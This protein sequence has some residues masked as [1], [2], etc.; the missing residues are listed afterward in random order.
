MAK[1]I[2]PVVGFHFNVSFIGLPKTKQLIVGFQSVDGLNVKSENKF[3]K[4]GGENRFIHQLPSQNIYKPLILKKG[5]I[6]EEDS[7]LLNWCQD[8]FQNNIKQPISGIDI[9]VL[10]EQHKVLLRWHLFHVWPLRWE[11]G[12]LNAE[13]GEIL[14]E[15]LV[16]K[17]NYFQLV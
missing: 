17:Y 14:I 12:K 3:L 2:Y 10:D 9:D 4:E 8:A 5:I 7:E 13:K 1:D 11:I 15:T 16:L 6:K